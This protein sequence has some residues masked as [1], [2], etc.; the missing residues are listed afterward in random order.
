MRLLYIGAAD[1]EIINAALSGIGKFDV[2]IGF[3]TEV[4]F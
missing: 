3:V 4:L 2:K 1:T